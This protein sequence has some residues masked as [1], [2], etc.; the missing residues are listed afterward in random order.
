MFTLASLTQLE[1][2]DGIPVLTELEAKN[3][4]FQAI[5]RV[6][7]PDLASAINKWL[8]APV[9]SRIKP[10]WKNLLSILRLI[11]LEHL[12]ED[13]ETAGG[14]I[15]KLRDE[16]LVL[17]NELKEGDDDENI[18]HLRSIE[19]RSKSAIEQIKEKREM[20]VDL[21]TRQPSPTMIP[22]QLGT[23]EETK[24]VKTEPASPSVEDLD[25][26]TQE[27]VMSRLLESTFC[28]I[29]EDN[30]YYLSTAATMTTQPLVKKEP[31]EEALTSTATYSTG[32]CVGKFHYVYDY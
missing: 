15:K 14:D 13:I 9:L 24:M 7:Q 4:E 8:T 11:N 12:A 26:S 5:I 23:A 3:H 16:L 10:T 29:I 31:L 6:K 22:P 18:H 30:N 28:I 25:T 1:K 27:T 21:K 19:T 2:R 20:L 17:C 32:M